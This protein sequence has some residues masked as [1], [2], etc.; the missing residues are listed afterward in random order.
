MV[1]L[2][3]DL[4]SGH[5]TPADGNVFADLGFPS[6][7][8]TCSWH[9]TCPDLTDCPDPRVKAPLQVVGES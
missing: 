6:G 4:R 8:G 7:E 3:E 9:G 5:L 2:N 1:M